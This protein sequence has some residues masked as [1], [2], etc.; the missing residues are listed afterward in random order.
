MQL[1]NQRLL[2]VCR[3][4]GLGGTEKVVLQLCE[5]FRDK[6]DY[7]AVASSGGVYEA[8]LR[9]LGV[10]H[11]PVPDIASKNPRDV[12]AIAR[13]LRN[14][15]AKKRITIIHSHHRMA[16]LYASFFL[17]NTAQCV[18]SHNVFHDKKRLT[19]FAYKDA[20]IAACGQQ[21]GRNLLEYYGLPAE[22]VRIIPNSVPS[23]DG[24]I[25]PIPEI[26]S[27]PKEVF[28]VGFLGRLAKQKGPVY[29]I[30]A[31]SILVQ[32]GVPIHCFFAGEGELEPD[33]KK[34]IEAMGCDDCFTFLGR[35]DDP[36]NFLAQLDV[37]V[38]PSLW[39]GLPLS[40]LEAFSV[41][42]PVIAS[43]VDGVL[44]MASDGENGILVK[45]EDSSALADAIALLQNNP[46]LRCKLGNNAQ[47]AYRE[48]HSY[49]AWVAQYEDLYGMA[50]RY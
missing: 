21:V 17:N 8:N 25:S 23:F 5:A 31:V 11:F 10:D 48:E 36:Q 41:G 14:I 24:A 4:M 34:L 16:A 2:M 49:R 15:V 45:P 30:E 22:R 9:A 13:S 27:I 38:L 18:T 1:S 19:G 40:L 3:T 26:A 39:E 50:C 28:K 20:I 6:F 43:A 42:T 35:R 32:R 7:L 12:I 46:E 47:I 44:D 37:F 33:L 29:L